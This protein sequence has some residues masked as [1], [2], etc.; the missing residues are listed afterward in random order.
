[1]ILYL[2]STELNSSSIANQ[3]VIQVTY[4]YALKENH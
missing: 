3:K 1:M 2:T 4:Q